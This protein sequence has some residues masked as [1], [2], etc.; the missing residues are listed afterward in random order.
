MSTFYR[1]P[2]IEALRTSIARSTDRRI[3]AGQF[4]RV[5]PQG[6]DAGLLRTKKAA[7]WMRLQYG[8]PEPKLLFGSFWAE[9]ELCILFADTGLGKSI[10][11]V[12]I[13]DSLTKEYS[14]G[15]FTNQLDAAVCV[16]YVDFELSSKQFELRYY[17][18][19]Y[20]SHLF[21]DLFYR[22]EFNPEADD[23]VLY[24]DYEEYIS[25]AIE[26]A[27][28]QTGARILII[29][30]ITY[31][32]RG[33]ERAG[34]ALPLMKM[35]RALKA[36]HG[37]SILVLAHTPKRSPYKPITV[38]DLQGSKLLINFADSA[39][40]IG[41][42]HTRPGLRYLKQVKQRSRAELYG[43]D[44]VCLIGSEKKLNFLGW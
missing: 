27:V 7:E 40:A 10:L 19:Q 22:A 21:S 25:S 34:E 4:G 32:R 26:N 33:T 39:F 44:N 29:D 8:K 24:D 1:P 36:K 12:Q 17:D 16:L 9:G 3:K 15:P 6:P 30:N 14:I 23:P 20:G 37:L 2:E 28:R 5:F 41:S 42:S 18:R 31:I 38:N 13:A 35:F 43:A 11:A